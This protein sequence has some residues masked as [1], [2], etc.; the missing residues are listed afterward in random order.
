MVDVATGRLLWSARTKYGISQGILVPVILH[1]QAD[2][3]LPEVLTVFPG[4]WVA[5]GAADYLAGRLGWRLSR[6]KGEMPDS[7]RYALRSHRDKG[8]VVEPE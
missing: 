6:R 8:W 2:E 3:D 4:E 1:P 5:K 7:Y